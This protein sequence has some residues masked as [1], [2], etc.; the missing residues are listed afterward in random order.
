MDSNKETYAKY[1]HLYTQKGLDPAERMILKRFQRR[2]ADMDVLDIGVGMGR[3]AYAF[4]AVCANYTGIDYVPRSI[5]FCRELIGEDDTVRFVQ[6]DARYLSQQFPKKFDF[7]MFALCG[8]DSVDH[9]GRYMVLREV[10]KCLKPD[11]Y[12][13]FSAHSLNAP[14]RK[15]ILPRFNPLRPIRSAYRVGKTALIH[16]RLKWANR[17]VDAQKERGWAI[18]KDNLEDQ[19]LDMYFISPRLQVQQLEETGFQVVEVYDRYG[20]TIDC[21]VP[22]NDLWLNYL[23][24]PKGPVDA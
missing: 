1:V 2:W 16:Y 18:V 23:C 13:F 3:T 10:R 11:G 20:R 6:C 7:I 24:Q 4:S 19:F 8:I 17:M 15:L 21:S 9:P 12:F 14:A 22:R 5:E